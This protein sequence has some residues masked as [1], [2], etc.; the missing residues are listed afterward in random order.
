M[1]TPP[2][3]EHG[4][5]M[6]PMECQV[7]EWKGAPRPITSGT[8]LSNCAGCCVGIH[9]ALPSLE[10]AQDVADDGSSGLSATG[11]YICASGATRSEG[12]R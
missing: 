2:P 12:T 11:A 9:M 8:L 5:A 3:P 1:G 4:P 10:A 6:V 7:T